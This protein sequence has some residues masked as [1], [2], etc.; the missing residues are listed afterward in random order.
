MNKTFNIASKDALQ[1]ITN[2]EDKEFLKRQLNDRTGCMGSKDLV[3][4]NREKRKQ[5]RDDDAE[6]RRL[7]A[8]DQQQ[9]DNELVEWYDSDSEQLASQFK[10]R[11]TKDPDVWVDMLKTVSIDRINY[12]AA[13]K[14][15]YNN[16]NRN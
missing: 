16:N 1:K 12:S 15:V 9:F 7:K 6:N 11:Q 2:E 13:T 3:L 8:I 10:D 14:A 5:K 4:A